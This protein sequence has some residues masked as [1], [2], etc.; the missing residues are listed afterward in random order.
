M[1]DAVTDSINGNY[2]QA[3]RELSAAYVEP[4]WLTETRLEALDLF[5]STPMP[6]RRDSAWRYTDLRKVSFDELVLP[7]AS[8]VQCSEPAKVKALEGFEEIADHAAVMIHCEGLPTNLHIP[9]S[10]K[11]RGATVNTWRDTTSASDDSLRD[12]IKAE[13][14]AGANDRFSMLHRAFVNSATVVHVPA[15]V[16]LDEPLFNI[17]WYCSDGR[18]HA[19]KL[20]VHLE[21]GAKASIV[22]IIGGKGRNNM[23]IPSYNFDLSAN[24]SLRYLRM[25]QS[26]MTTTI[27]GYQTA[28]L[29][30]ESRATTAVVNLGGK[31]VRDVIEAKMLEPGANTKMLGLYV[32][33]GDQHFDHETL[34]DHIAGSCSS[35]LLFKGALSGRA[36]AVFNGKIVVRPGAQKTDAFQKNRSILLSKES[37]AD[38]VPQLEISADDVRCSHG[39]TVSRVQEPD[40]FYLMS[41]G[42][43]RE[44]AEET[45]VFGFL[46]EVINKLD[47]PDMTVPLECRVSHRIKTW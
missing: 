18:L 36:R 11:E 42:L 2:E 3:V 24:S 46:D 14:V 45:L 32:P 5:K 15:G 12:I 19:P 25:Q 4:E 27:F 30:R 28:R 37:R 34:Q 26:D 23:L 8:A 20:I 31:L 44:R 7:S 35:D 6:T 13:P 22:D 33:G 43:T 38:S 17:L 21:T 47:W 29:G 9:Y 40:V 10:W 1:S 39:A 41:R 16:Q